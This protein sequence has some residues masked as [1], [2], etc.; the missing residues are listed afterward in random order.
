M[1]CTST[2]RALLDTALTPLEAALRPLLSISSV[3]SLPPI[4]S[5]ILPSPNTFFSFSAVA[6][7]FSLD[8]IER[9]TTTLSS[10]SRYRFSIPSLLDR[11]NPVCQPLRVLVEQPW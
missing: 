5:F 1:L 10:R 4:R 9:T 3:R 11:L 8:Q 2:N 6:V 7:P